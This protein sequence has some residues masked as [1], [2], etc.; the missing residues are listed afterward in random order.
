MNEKY[1]QTGKGHLVRHCFYAGELVTENAILAV[2]RYIDLNAKRAGL[3]DKPEDWPWCSFAA[4]LG[5]AHARPFHQPAELLQ[6]LAPS[7]RK[8]RSEYRRFVYDGLAQD[9]LVQSSDEGDETVTGRVVV[10][11]V[12]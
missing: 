1:D 8:A 11:S 3:C 10:E 2:A 6:L 5:A 12:A 4:T 9:A 7:P